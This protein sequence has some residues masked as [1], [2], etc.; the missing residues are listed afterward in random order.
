MKAVI[1]VKFCNTSL[2]QDG[3]SRQVPRQ[4]QWLKCVVLLRLTVS[5][6]EGLKYQRL[7]LHVDVM[8]VVVGH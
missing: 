7:S 6:G 2:Q 5:A 4:L 1:E 8:A 3:S